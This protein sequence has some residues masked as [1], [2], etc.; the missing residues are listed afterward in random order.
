MFFCSNQL[1]QKAAFEFNARSVKQKQPMKK[2]PLRLLIVSSAALL[3]ASCALVSENLATPERIAKLPEPIKSMV[4]Q[5]RNEQKAVE[6]RYTQGTK[7]MLRAYSTIADAIGMKKQAAILM[8]E[9]NALK[10]G[11]SLSDA[12][13][14]M[15]RSAGIIKEVRNKVASSKGVTVAS[16]SKFV[17][18]VQIK[19]QAYMVQLTLATDASLKAYNAVQKAKGA[20]PLE[21]AILTSQLDPLFF[22]VRDVPK[23]L[24]QER[25][26][27]D[28]CKDY[29]KEQK[30]SL[31]PA[32]LP[33]PKLSMN[34]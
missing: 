31:P 25:A 27:N 29:A 15:S 16:K 34:F 11:S 14:A 22:I 17:E 20:G 28:I 33:T 21:M 10:A 9:S 12:R 5:L 24:A 26:F 8:A 30:I 2:T 3:L 4:I 1:T 7:T 32:N 13:K 19:N 6:A 23:F 18:G